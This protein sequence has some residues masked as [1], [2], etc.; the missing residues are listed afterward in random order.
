MADVADVRIA[1]RISQ[2]EKKALDKYCED[3]HTSISWVIREALRQ[4]LSQDR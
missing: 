2:Q 4:F 3:N 1:G